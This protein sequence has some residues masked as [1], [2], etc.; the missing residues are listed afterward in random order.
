M[1]KKN[2][3]LIINC[4]KENIKDI[5]I[6]KFNNHYSKIYFNIN[7]NINSILNILTTQY[8]SIWDYNSEY[9]NINNL[10]I[11]NINNSYYIVFYLFFCT[12]NWCM[13]IFWN[14]FSSDRNNH[15]FFNSL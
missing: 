8:Y 2:I 15:L 5:D 14:Y 9:K 7:D 6:N 10:F 1:N 3:S 13:S 11:Y 4:N 12:N